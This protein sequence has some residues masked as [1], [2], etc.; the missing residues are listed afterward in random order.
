MVQVPRLVLLLLAAFALFATDARAQRC[1]APPG[2]AAIDQYCETVPTAGGD[3]GSAP[4]AAP[5]GVPPR[6]VRRLAASGDDGAALNRLLGQAP[7]SGT[8]PASTGRQG[9]KGRPAVEGERG[10][11]GSRTATGT[12]RTRPPSGNPLD[13][14]RESVAGGTTLGSSFGWLLLGVTLALAA[15]AWVGVRGRRSS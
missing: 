8:G 3:R 2:T 7:E 6:T 15:W 10:R 11:G 5:R 4:P 1:V 9:G 14:V 13:A 12:A